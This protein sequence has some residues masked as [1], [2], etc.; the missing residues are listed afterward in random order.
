MKS[1]VSC[2]EGRQPGSRGEWTGKRNVPGQ[3][4]P[5]GRGGGGGPTAPTLW[6]LAHPGTCPTASIAGEAPAP[7]CSRGGSS[8]GVSCPWVRGQR[9]LGGG[10][11]AGTWPTLPALG[12]DAFLPRCPAQ[13]QP[14]SARAPRSW[15]SSRLP[16]SASPP[17]SSN[18]E[19]D[20]SSVAPW[21][22][23]PRGR[24]RLGELISPLAWGRVQAQSFPFNNS[25]PAGRAECESEC[26]EAQ[27][28]GTLPAAERRSCR[29]SRSPANV[30]V[31]PPNSPQAVAAAA[32]GHRGTFHGRADASGSHQA[33]ALWGLQGWSPLVP[34]FVGAAGASGWAAGASA[35]ETPNDLSTAPGPGWPPPSWGIRRG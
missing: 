17:Q 13:R 9:G 29:A 26:D 14:G 5:P 8:S 10:E 24:L 2:V 4:L 35:R 20:P 30:R 25:L 22:S 34:F 28:G 27:L 31:E 21:S 33:L 19:G 7:A 3:A 15:H 32:P 6:L 18:A 23:C 12:P 1:L 16:E 11:R